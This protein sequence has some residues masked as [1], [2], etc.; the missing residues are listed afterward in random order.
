MTTITE[1]TKEALA[2]GK[3][4]GDGHTIFDPNFYAP[5]FSEDELRK[6]GLLITLKSDYSSPKSTI[7]DNKTGEAVDEMTGIYNL[8][9]LEWLAV[10]VGVTDYRICNGR[11]SQAQAIV[12]ALYEALV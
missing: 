5:Y 7:F 8:S 3:I 11:G 6:A 9:F 10:R 4:V 12:D 1:R 2:N